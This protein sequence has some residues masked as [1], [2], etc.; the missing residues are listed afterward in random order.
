M[1]P[2]RRIDYRL[3]ATTGRPARRSRVTDPGELLLF[4]T[5]PQQLDAVFEFGTE[6]LSPASIRLAD[7]E[8]AGC[9][10]CDTDE[11]TDD[12]HESLRALDLD[13]DRWE[14]R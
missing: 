12:E 1:P 8:P 2:R 14:D 3:P 4:V 10:I 9:S 13:A 7:D 6:T 11:H 5:E